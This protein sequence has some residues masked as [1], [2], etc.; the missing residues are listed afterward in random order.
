MPNAPIPSLRLIAGLGTAI[1]AAFLACPA[2]AVTSPLAGQ[3]LYTPVEPCRI[4]DTRESTTGA[5]LGP[6]VER[7]FD[8]VGAV[9]MT[10]Q[11]GPLG[12]CNVPGYQGTTPG[13]VAVVVN[14]TAVSP[15]ANGNLNAWPADRD[16][17]LSSI[18][19][20]RAGQNLANAI[21]L[22]LAQDATQGDD[23]RVMAAHA[24]AHV[25]IDVVGY[26][27]KRTKTEVYVRSSSVSVGANGL[28]SAAASCDDSDDLPVS[29]ECDTV[30]STSLD[31]KSVRHSNWNSATTAAST[32]CQVFNSS[33]AAQTLTA[34][35]HCIPIQ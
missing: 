28:G 4:V 1:V 16:R 3:L 8:V 25:V 24:A 14:L 27:T 7:D 31:L 18:L 35:I 23:L 30:G 15:T 5:A 2:V 22:P 33:G 13:A 32:S 20:F 11:G 10:A 17:P 26:F 21:V 6:G 29:F 19:N 9:D 12:G 34:R